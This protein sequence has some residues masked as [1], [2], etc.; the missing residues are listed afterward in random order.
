VSTR[1]W[2]GRLPGARTSSTTQPPSSRAQPGADRPARTGDPDR[3]PLPRTGPRPRPPVP[4]PKGW[5]LRVVLISRDN[6]LAG[7]L[8]SLIEAPGGVRVLDWYSEELD[9]AIRHADVAIVD[10]PPN[11]HERAFA[12]IDGRFLGR[13]VVLLQEGEHAEA[14]PPGPP[15]TI[16]Y[17]P[18][19]IGELWMAVTGALPPVTE[20]DPSGPEET[21]Q[22]VDAEV[23]RA[24]G[25]EGPEAQ[26]GLERPEPEA[27]PEPAPESGPEPEPEAQ[28]ELEPAPEPEPDQAPGLPEPPEAELAADG[29]ATAGDD[30][31]AQ[32]G[33]AAVEAG[34]VDAA[35][36]EVESQGLPVAES[37]RLIGLSGQ[38]LDP[39]IGPGQVAPGMDHAT[40]ER[41]RGWGTGGSQPTARGTGQSPGARR[42]PT[43]REE[44]RQAKAAQAE[45]RRAER[46][47]ADEAKAA[48]A[49]V[50][51]EHSARE[52]AARAEA[53]AAAREE[54]RQAKAAQEEARL[55]ARAEAER[56][57]AERTQARRVAREEARQAKAARA[58]ARTAAREEARQAKAAEAEAARAAREARAEAE[59]AAH[60]AKAEETRKARAAQ[61]EAELAALEAKAE[62]ARRARAAKAEAERVAQEAKAEA[63]RVAREARAEEARRAKAAKAEARAAAR[64]E[65]RQAKEA[66]AEA[67]QAARAEAKQARA[68]RSEE[69]RAARARSRQERAARAE[70]RR[71]E[72]VEAR[73]AK[74]AEEAAH[75]AEQAEA[76]R[77][78]AAA[79][80]A[81]RA[82]QA[83]AQRV[84]REEARQAKAERAEARKVARGEARQAKAERVEARRAGREEA[85]RSRAA[86]REEARQVRS[87]KA[88]VRRA[89]RAE[90]KQAKAA[91]AEARREQ[92]RR[93]RAERAAARKQARAE[94]GEARA[95]KAA[96][97]KAARAEARQAKATL[98][99]ERRAARAEARQAKAAQAE[100]Q[101][102]A[103]AQAQQ[104]KAA[105]AELR[106]EEARQ[107]KAAQ[108]EERR[109][110]WAEAER[111]KA[112]QAEA[113]RQEAEQAKAG[114]AEERRA[115]RAEAAEAKVVQA[116][117]RKVER[118]AARAQAR[119]V[120]AADR[121]VRAEARQVRV[122]P[123]RLGVGAMLPA[124]VVVLA[125]AAVGPGAAGWRGAGGPD[126]LA[127]E[128][129]VVRAAGGGGGL[130]AQDPRVGP[131]E[132]LHALAVGAW[133]RATEAGASLEGA[134]R[135]ARVPSRFLLAGVVVLTVLLFLL[136]MRVG[137]G[138]GAAAGP[139]PAPP[140]L[141]G[142]GGRGRG[143]RLGAAALA[144][145]LAALDPMLVL[146]G[147]VATGTL[148]AVVLALGALVVAW[149]LPT[150]PTLRWLP[151]V[152]AVGGLALLVSPL[153]LP[154][155]AVPVVAE[156]L[157]GRHREAWRDMA[158]L[159][160]GIGVWLALPIW[161]AGQ[162]L[163]AGQAGWLLGRPPGRGAIAAS[164][165]A[166]PLTWLLVA[167][168][169]AAAVLPWRLR[170]GA[171]SEATP[172]RARLLAW[173]ATT[174][175]GALVAIVLGYP[176]AQAL[177]FAVPA[178][179][180]SVAVAAAR[181]A[182]GA[183]ARRAPAVS[184]L[185]VAGVGVA[186]AGLLVAQGGDWAA[187]YGTSADDGL[188]RLVATVAGKLPACSAVNASGP[189]DRARLLAA[190]A[191]VTEFS[192]GPAALAAG[193]RYFVVTGATAQGGP[194]TPSLAAW[195][196]QHGTRVAVHP[197]RSLAGVEL[198][199]VEAAPLDPV[200]DSLPVPGGV[201]SNTDGS[202]CGGY[203][204]VDGQAGRFYTAYQAAGGKAVLGRPLGGV[205]TSD[206][207]ALQAFDT[208]VLGA[209]PASS[210]PPAVAPIELPPLL[211]KLDVEAVADADI[212][213]P[214]ARPPV[215]DRQAQ[216]LLKD[217]LIARE[218]LGTDP[219]SA[220][221]AD[222]RRAR[223]RF[224]RP[225]GLP[226]VMP[227]G[228]V[229]QTF[230]RVV[231]ELPADGG[232]ARPA[233]LG[234]LAVRLGLVPRQAM[235]P[236]PAPGLPTRPAETRLDTGPLLRLAGGAL[237]LLALAAGAGVVVAWRSRPTH[238]G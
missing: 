48:E 199:L 112:S 139:G 140:Q 125:M 187:R 153:A 29:E 14:L 212:P 214:S 158:A 61:A 59:R 4:E 180:V 41:L 191:I 228:A 222:W 151:L 223:A 74:A 177:P 86:R 167:A 142:R 120:K 117:A 55:A 124:A 97:R 200:A 186:L 136:L 208:M 85:G 15:R 141:L 19:Q 21:H 62:E 231:L 37:G 213:L 195:V 163:D 179:A 181:L 25:S 11:L 42:T 114:R 104:A 31:V 72:Q 1:D 217:E 121:Q 50:R 109:L 226:Q 193:V 215:T 9:A 175:A 131:I 75:R 122:A 184:R 202:A 219:G 204:V 78:A 23:G 8:R 169:L 129:A 137:P 150:R 43:G 185:V 89:A 82:E 28:V 148:L 233:A 232:P 40:L 73:Q 84:A 235:R 161:V 221:A 198:W 155:L 79:A 118:E 13:T 218:Y 94:A 211:A 54:A 68:T 34:Q 190:G 20:P 172:G 229:R 105:E 201:F 77:V 27:R 38:E 17:R 116:A 5:A 33:V 146:N 71:A 138:S 46:E 154:L 162:G 93:A 87:A 123:R 127:G 182:A 101:R 197:S 171:R 44:A 30:G 99:E 234:R 6:M 194:M 106:R 56:E 2:V 60:E 51:R 108:A 134:T 16:L 35:A 224:G 133:L 225:L 143:W 237:A 110:A 230:E 83:E 65:S 92:S 47:A 130:V 39:V 80:Q 166:A 7:A 220:S 81:R 107:A 227:D 147:R 206:G 103:R 160:L 210:G 90:A 18:V 24:A 57:R 22:P 111:A 70:A 205:W 165:A 216:A 10:M 119:Q 12:V 203:R 170:A 113:R 95:A 66:R 135:E 189:D 36:V 102:A 100:E 49:Q 168:G 207:P 64:E 176:A 32:A 67:R 164:L 157:Q 196:R 69:R 159:G 96:A 149:G 91:A 156:L 26:V 144:G 128:V 132:P 209:I 126:T 98:A 63:E 174:A 188:D 192:D 152:A 3:I 145:G 178:A 53:E 45:A 238:S 183:Q 58:A 115:A 173:T 236:E 76:K 52:R 88:E